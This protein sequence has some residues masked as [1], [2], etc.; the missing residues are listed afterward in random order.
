MA[1]F[2][3]CGNAAPVLILHTSWILGLVFDW[4]TKGIW[5]QVFHS[6]FSCINELDVR[7]LNHPNWPTTTQ[8]MVH[9]IHGTA[10]TLFLPYTLSR[11]WDWFSVGKQREFRLRFS[12]V[13]VA[14]S[15]NLMLGF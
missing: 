2:W 8:V 5:T 10:T 4:E 11:T 14:K 7:L 13:I 1:E 3:G 15:V 6:N 12:I 9:L